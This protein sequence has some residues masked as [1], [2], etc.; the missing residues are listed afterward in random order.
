MVW[1]S[2]ICRFSCVILCSN[3]SNKAHK[4]LPSTGTY[5][6][7]K[8][9]K[10]KHLAEYTQACLDNGWTYLDP[11]VKLPTVGENRKT[12]LPPFSPE[13]LL[14]YLVRFVTADDQVSGAL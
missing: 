10:S 7:R 13:T 6:L 9:L 14:E 8:H 3:C 5:N 11:E 1:V 2:G 12:A 4:Y